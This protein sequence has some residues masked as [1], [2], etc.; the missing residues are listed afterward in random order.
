LKSDED[1]VFGYFIPQADLIR[2][3]NDSWGIWSRGGL[4]TDKNRFPK[5]GVMPLLA[6]L[7]AETYW[8]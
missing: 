7:N 2:W 6:A 5:G 4:L 3:K 8:R 1:N